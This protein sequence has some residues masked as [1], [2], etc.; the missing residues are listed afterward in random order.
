[1]P[2]ERAERSKQ[3]SLIDAAGAPAA[4]CGRAS[5]Q[6]VPRD[7]RVPSALERFLRCL[8]RRALERTTLGVRSNAAVEVPAAS[9]ARYER[10]R[11]FA[12]RVSS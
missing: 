8:L 4:P 3:R 12:R 7:V 10:G 2:A 1:M 5:Y 9:T 11:A 6:C